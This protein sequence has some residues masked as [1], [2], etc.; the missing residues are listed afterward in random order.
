MNHKIEWA[1]TI[2]KKEKQ[3]KQALIWAHNL[4]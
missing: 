3:V 1:Q 2:E 4:L